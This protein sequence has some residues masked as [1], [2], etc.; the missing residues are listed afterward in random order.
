MGWDEYWNKNM[1]NIK[2]EAMSAP[3]AEAMSAP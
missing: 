1:K 3:Q 2:A